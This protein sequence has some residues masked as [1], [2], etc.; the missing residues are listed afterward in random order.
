M[1]KSILEKQEWHF[2]LLALLVVSANAIMVIYPMSFEG[3]LWGLSTA[4]WFWIGVLTA[5]L[6][7]V[8][9]MLIWRIQLETRWLTINLPRLGFTAYLIDYTWMLAARTGAI[10]LVA[11]ANQ[12]N[13]YIPDFFKW[14][15]SIILAVVFLGLIYSIASSSNYKDL[16]GVTFFEV[17][18]HGSYKA[19]KQ[20]Y[21]LVPVTFYFLGSLGF[22]VPGI[23]FSS[24]ASLL[25]AFF[26]HLY[27]CIHYYCTEVPSLKRIYN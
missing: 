17:N 18:D 24:P 8:Y 20:V 14:T 2:A 15:G 25:L 23:L 5:I 11:I 19:E 1:F 16:V 21:S 13:I 22:Y 10:V 4:S 7:Q 12:D 6:H 26:N 27:I 3:V 9:V